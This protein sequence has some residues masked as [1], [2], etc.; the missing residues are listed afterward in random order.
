M[1]DKKRPSKNAVAINEVTDKQ[2]IELLT[3]INKGMAI[4]FT[5]VSLIASL[6]DSKHKRRCK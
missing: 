2:I 6:V 5:K 1:T 3:I 4:K